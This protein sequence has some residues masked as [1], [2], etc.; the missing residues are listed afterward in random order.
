[1]GHF[2]NYP[3]YS[4][5]VPNTVGHE[6]TVYTTTEGE[7]IVELSV[8]IFDPPSG[9]APQPFTLSINTEDGTAG[10]YM[11]SYTQLNN[12][13][14]CHVRDDIGISYIQCHVHC[15]LLLP[16]PVSPADYNGVANGILTFNLG[17]ERVTHTIIINPDDICENDTYE[18]FFSNLTLNS[19]FQSITVIRPR[20]QIIINDTLEPECSK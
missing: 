20:A 15:T 7:G 13:Y 4:P 11:C 8:V 1:M 18:D 19:G 17:D 5:T 10:I 14:N 2:N 12:V 3:I 16:H 9:G 6:F